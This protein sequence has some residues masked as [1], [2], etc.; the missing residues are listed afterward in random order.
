MNTYCKAKVSSSCLIQ[1]VYDTILQFQMFIANDK[2]KSRKNH[3]W[4]K[5]IKTKDARRQCEIRKLNIIYKSPFNHIIINMISDV[6]ILNPKQMIFYPN[7]KFITIPIFTVSSR[8]QQLPS[9]QLGAY[10]CPPFRC[11]SDPQYWLLF[12]FP[13]RLLS[14]TL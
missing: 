11:I 9:L 3:L 7:F 10:S 13:G 8:L 14:Y 1:L 6:I 5:H 12:Q 2:L 4:R